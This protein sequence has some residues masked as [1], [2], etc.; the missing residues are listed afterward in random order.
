MNGRVSASM[1]KALQA[2]LS[3]NVDNIGTATAKALLRRGLWSAERNLTREGWLH[4]V[5]NESLEVQSNALELPIK[6]L[7]NWSWTRRPEISAYEHYASE[8]FIGSYCEGGAILLLIRAAALNYLH[9]INTFGS[10][11]DAVRRFTEAQLAIHSDKL[12]KLCHVV[13]NASLFEVRENFREIYRDPYVQDW[14]PGLDDE[15]MLAIASALSMSCLSKITR[16]IG[17]DPYRFRKGW[18]DLTLANSKGKMIWAEV[19]TTDKLLT[20]QIDTISNFRHLM[21]GEIILVHLN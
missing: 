18:P 2:S 9:E 15:K 8:G 13:K 11:G 10:R 17:S 12:D 16:A 20:S 14:Y 21:P 19:K 6:E 7:K 3:G 5:A 1:R 4:A